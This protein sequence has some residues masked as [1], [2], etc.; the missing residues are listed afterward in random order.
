VAGGGVSGAGGRAYRLWGSGEGWVF[1]CFEN[2]CVKIN[3][4]YGEQDDVKH[5]AALMTRF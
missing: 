5:A 1:I 3:R 2:Q 4:T